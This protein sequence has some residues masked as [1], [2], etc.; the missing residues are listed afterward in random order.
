MLN[1]ILCKENGEI[2]RIK[3]GSTE[4]NDDLE[5]ASEFN[6]YFINSIVEINESIPFVAFEDDA[7]LNQNLS[8]QFHG[9][10]ITDIK[11]CLRELK[12]NTDEYFL[13]PKVLLDAI[14]VI[15]QQLVST[16][17]DSFSEGVF[18]DALKKSTIIPIQKIVG[19]VDISDHR[20]INTLPCI[21]RLI[22]SLAYNQF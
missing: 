8:F 14:F 4:F 16:I 20:P 19:S 1:S 3:I 15:G 2:T 13:N 10:S 18:P 5:I 9:V 21:E 17:N 11:C 6:K 22:E 7:V 12:N